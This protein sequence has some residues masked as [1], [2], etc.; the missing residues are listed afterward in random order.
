MLSNMNVGLEL[1]LAYIQLRIFQD[2]LD[3]TPEY[4]TPF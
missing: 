1:A 4:T 3:R 2:I